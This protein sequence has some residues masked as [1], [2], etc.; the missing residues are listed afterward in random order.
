MAIA[1]LAAVPGDMVPVVAHIVAAGTGSTDPPL[2]RPPAVAGIPARTVDRAAGMH[3][4]AAAE[5]G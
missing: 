5:A 4:H 2:D 3:L 1:P